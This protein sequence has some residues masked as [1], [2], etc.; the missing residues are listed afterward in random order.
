MTKNMLNKETK[1]NIIN[2]LSRHAIANIQDKCY[3]LA[4]D[5]LAIICI[6]RKIKCDDN[7]KN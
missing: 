7:E 1:E 3:Q 4:I 2:I 5:L 6:I